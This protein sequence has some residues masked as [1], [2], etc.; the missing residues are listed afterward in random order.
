[1]VPRLHFFCGLAGAGKST[2][3]RQLAEAPGHLLLSED[4]W[5]ASLYGLELNTLADYGRL[6]PRLR[7]ALSPH[8]L[9]L[10]EQGLSLVLDFPLNTKAS[11][12][13][14]KDL[15]AQ[16]ALPHQLHWLDLAQPQCLERLLARNARGE[17]PFAPTQEQFSALCGYFEAPGAD[18][19]FCLL[20][21]QSG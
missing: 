17:H 20:R 18:E 6:A 1:M 5:L 21:H 11:R 12:A 14:A 10:L 2:L 3:A 13:W 9:A 8:L 4:Q 16:S 7:T 19:G 15:V